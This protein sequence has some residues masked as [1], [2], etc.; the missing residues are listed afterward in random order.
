MTT[1]SE[2]RAVKGIG[3]TDILV[4]VK[5]FVGNKNA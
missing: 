5:S 1:G 4:E 2:E 3:L